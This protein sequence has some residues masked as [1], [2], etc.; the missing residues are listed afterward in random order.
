MMGPR[1]QWDP[2]EAV[3]TTLEAAVLIIVGLTLLGTIVALVVQIVQQLI[4]QVSK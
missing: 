3:A 4:A 1:R 2:G